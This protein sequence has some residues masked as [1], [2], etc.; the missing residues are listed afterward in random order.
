MGYLYHACRFDWSITF[1]VFRYGIITLIT[2]LFFYGTIVKFYDS[3][4]INTYLFVAFNSQNCFDFI[5]FLFVKCPIDVSKFNFQAHSTFKSFFTNV[6]LQGC[7]SPSLNS[8]CDAYMHVC[9][10]HGASSLRCLSL[11]ILCELKREKLTIFVLT[12]I[13]LGITMF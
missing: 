5:D 2:F 9:S 10:N 6:H 4:Q 11:H 12:L 13:Y 3:F 7:G 8:H 1:S